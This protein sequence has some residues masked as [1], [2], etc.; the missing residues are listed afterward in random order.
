MYNR[1]HSFIQHA[2]KRINADCSSGSTYETNTTLG[3]CTCPDYL[4]N[5][6]PCKHL[7]LEAGTGNTGFPDNNPLCTLD[8]LAK[9][10]RRD[11][12]KSNR[13]LAYI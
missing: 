2:L 9:D 13:R 4:H 7:L 10:M 1:P 5:G 12:G 6:L 3:N 11:D 8:T